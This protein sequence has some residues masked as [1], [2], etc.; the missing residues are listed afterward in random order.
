VFRLEQLTDD[1]RARALQERALNR[2]LKLSEEVLNW[3]L[4]HHD[5]DMGRLTALIDTLD[6]YS[7]ERHRPITLPLLKELL[8]HPSAPGIP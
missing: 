7:L 4:T 5:R 2:G 8:A 6:H 1:E 3:I